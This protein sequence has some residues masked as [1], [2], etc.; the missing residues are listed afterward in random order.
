MCTVSITVNEEAIRRINPSLTSKEAIGQWLQRQVDIMLEDLSDIAE[1]PPCCYNS[2]EE[3]ISET[4][5]RMKDIESG[6]T[7]MTPHEEVRQKMENL[8]AS[9][10]N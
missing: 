5:R 4:Q 8:I 6:K 3:V 10:A 1:E 7:Q 9:Y 2:V